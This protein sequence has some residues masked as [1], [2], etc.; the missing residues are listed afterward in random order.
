MSSVKRKEIRRIKQ[1]D[2]QYAATT[3]AAARERGLETSL[4]EVSVDTARL[5]VL[6]AMDVEHA[7][8]PRRI[9]ALER[10]KIAQEVEIDVLKAK[11]VAAHGLADQAWSQL[12]AKAKELKELK[13]EVET[14]RNNAKSTEIV[15]LK[16]QLHQVRLDLSE[17]LAAE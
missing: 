2:R 10:Q 9:S 5:V 8:C 17:A 1:R 14:L 16:A 11:A 3:A 15:R 6:E 13:R 12:E 7:K 4:E